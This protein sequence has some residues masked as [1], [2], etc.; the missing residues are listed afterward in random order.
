MTA[1]TAAPPLPPP[2]LSTDDRSLS[3]A[4]GGG[5]RCNELIYSSAG[6]LATVAG[7]DGEGTLWVKLLLDDAENDD[8]D[9]DDDDENLSSLPW[10]LV[11]TALRTGDDGEDA[12]LSMKVPEHVRIDFE[13]AQA[14]REQRRQRKRAEA[15][16]ARAAAA[17]AAEA[18]QAK[19]QQRRRAVR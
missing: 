8:D 19:K 1:A 12:A 2:T 17:A 5:L 13:A 15:A 14:R 3:K 9:D 4:F 10:A 7:V 16:R 6:Q 18:E 11:P